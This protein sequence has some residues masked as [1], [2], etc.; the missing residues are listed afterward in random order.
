[1][2][3]RMLGLYDLFK[4]RQQVD[5]AAVPT[6]E[7]FRSLTQEQF[8][9]IMGTMPRMNGKPDWGRIFTVEEIKQWM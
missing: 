2:M 8:S 1:M 5:P 9:K 4:S 6:V 3:Y 7:F